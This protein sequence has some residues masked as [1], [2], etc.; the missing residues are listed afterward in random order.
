MSSYP[1][2]FFDQVSKRFELAQGAPRT[3]QEQLLALVESLTRSPDDA[4][5]E[6]L[7]QLSMLLRRLA[8]SR[9]PRSKVASLTGDTP[10]PM[11]RISQ[12]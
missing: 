10:A 8:L 4:P 7:A 3:I 12:T 11:S 5:V 9:Y 1:A 6:K 2:I